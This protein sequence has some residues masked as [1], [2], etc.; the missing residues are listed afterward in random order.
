MEKLCLDEGETPHSL[1][2]A[3]AVTLSLFGSA[4][5]EKDIMGHVGCFSNKS[6]DWYSEIQKLVYVGYVSNL[7]AQ[8]SK[9]YDAENIY[10]SCGDIG[11]L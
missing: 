4:S 3:C 2:R 6:L 8:V 9:I 11:S 10:N 5:A 7:F 1:R